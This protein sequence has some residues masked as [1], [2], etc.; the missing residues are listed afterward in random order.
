M[1]RIARGRHHAAFA[2]LTAPGGQNATPS[3]TAAPHFVQ[4]GISPSH[5]TV[6]K[7]SLDLDRVTPRFW[8]AG[9]AKEG[10]TRDGREQEVVKRAPPLRWRIVADC[11]LSGEPS[12]EA[13]I[14]NPLPCCI[15]FLNTSHRK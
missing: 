6:W 12:Q 4:R 1:C 10:S 2:R 9:G 15:L 8:T 13:S 7:L 5:L 11:I 14:L 3:A